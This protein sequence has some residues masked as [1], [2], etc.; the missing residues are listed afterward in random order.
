M[1]FNSVP[2]AVFLPVVFT[3]YWLFGAGRPRLQTAILLAASYVFYAWWDWR[4]LSLIVFVSIVNYAV[5]LAIG[6]ATDPRRRRL[7]L[8]TAL[9]V[10]L[11][12]LG[13]FKYLGFMIDSVA[14]L[15]AALGLK[16]DPPVLRILLPMGISFYTLQVVTY[17]LGIYYGR[18]EPT[19]RVL[20]FFAFTCFFPLLIAGPIE[21]AGRL[22]PQFLE[23]RVFDE[24]KM[25]D[26][27]R[28]I[29]N[30]LLK[31]VVIAD[32][33][34]P[35]V[36]AIFNDP[37][38]HDG[39][40]LLVGAV[41]FAFQVYCDFSGYSDIAIGVGRLF[42][43]SLMQNF[44]Y[45]FFSRDIGE[46]WR[47]WHIALSTWLRDYVFFPLGA[48]YGSRS[49]Q[50]FNVLVTFLVSGLWHGANWTFVCWGAINGLFFIP[51]ILGLQI[52]TYKRDVAAGRLLPTPR[53]ALAM[54]TTFLAVVL[55]FVFFRADS[56]GLAVD[57]LG[58]LFSRP[59]V[60]GN[61]QPL[62]PMLLA[63]A[64]LWL[65]EWVQRK[66]A[67]ALE[68]HRLP[69]A[70]RWGLYAAGIIAFLVFGNFGSQDFIYFQF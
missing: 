57:Y 24:A 51:L 17:P 15:L 30:G 38:A 48:A 67:Y 11:G 31:K 64:G 65:I 5:G 22:L 18:L 13:V 54:A 10:S 16:A 63:C 33:L 37:S 29:L 56:L 49:R 8:L 4:F 47:R 69:G 35:H 6:A 34:S 46:F 42:G 23:P 70:L 7:L 44:R 36:Q 28:Q 66:R 9:V 58:G 14:A 26:G 1:L 41:F 50:I 40:T 20:E 68:I 59:W 53:E 21:R 62:L 60:P 25:R 2:F 52:V 61:L 45:P 43:F 19:R 55:A 3:L 39:A 12:V 27:L 32:N